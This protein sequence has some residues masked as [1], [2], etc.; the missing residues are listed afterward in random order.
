[1]FANVLGVLEL[2]LIIIGTWLVLRQIKMGRDGQFSQLWLESEKDFVELNKL[3]LG[4]KV[5]R[6]TY[7]LNDPV[8]KDVDDDHL[9]KFVFYQTYY[10]FATAF[11]R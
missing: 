10:I 2:L 5:L 9:K 8:L 3:M 1:M 7:R 11:N 4:D 6:D